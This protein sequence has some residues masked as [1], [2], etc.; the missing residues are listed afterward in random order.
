MGSG[1]DLVELVLTASCNLKCAYCYQNDKNAASMS[2]ETARAALDRVLVPGRRQ[3]TIAFYGGEPLLRLPL[4]RRAVAHV[5][6]RR[7]PGMRVRYLLTTNGLLLDEKAVRFLAKHD[8]E[9]HL[10]FDGVPEAQAARGERT[11]ERLDRLLDEIRRLEPAYFEK[12]LSVGITFDS[13][14]M[15]HLPASLRYFLGKDLREVNVGPVITH[16]PGWKPESIEELDRIFDRLAG[17]SLEHYER[18]GTIPLAVLRG[19]GAGDAATPAARPMC[20]AGSGHTLSVD[21]DGDASGCLMLSRSFQKFPSKW[22]EGQLEPL[23]LGPVSDGKLRRRLAA[24]PQVSA[25]APL[26]SAKQDKHS[27][28][29]RCGECRFLA[30]CGVCPVS[31][32]HIPGNEDPS[33]VPDLLCA[34]NLVMLS[35]REKFAE[36]TDPWGIR[37]GTARIPPSIS[38]I[39]EI[40][41][42]VRVG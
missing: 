42:P 32:G 29:G 31:V 40:S 36:M 6:R 35:H 8:I 24:L 5:S 37:P 7:P 27:S 33:R 39:L 16:D 11:F 22:L 38:K 3:V 10:S 4:I 18:T 17:I 25:R 20:G 23:R 13:A 34:Y 26:F 30:S 1:P 41:P 2:W 9:T 19:G 28:Y 21:T 15:R 14:T 12:R